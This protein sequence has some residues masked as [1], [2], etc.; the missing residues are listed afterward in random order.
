MYA[1]DY[2][3]RVMQRVFQRRH[4]GAHTLDQKTFYKAP[5]RVLKKIHTVCRNRASQNYI[6]MLIEAVLDSLILK[7]DS[8]CKLLT[9]AY[10]AKLVILKLYCVTY[11]VYLYSGFY[12]TDRYKKMPCAFIYC[13]LE[14]LLMLWSGFMKPLGLHFE[15]LLHPICHLN[16]FWCSFSQWISGSK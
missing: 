1:S 2:R 13:G 3:P 6:L 4:I 8:L 7:W 9:I 15:V 5:T 16:F 14:H 11:T 12:K 10:R